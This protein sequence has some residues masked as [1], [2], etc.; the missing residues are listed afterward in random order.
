MLI[1]L[2]LTTCSTE[3]SYLVQGVMDWSLSCPKKRSRLSTSWYQLLASTHVTY[4]LPYSAILQRANIAAERHGLPTYVTQVTSNTMCL[5]SNYSA[6]M[7]G[8]AEE[9]ALGEILICSTV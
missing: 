2:A 4:I 6:L 3:I 1:F 9:A 8:Q 7:Y 5:A